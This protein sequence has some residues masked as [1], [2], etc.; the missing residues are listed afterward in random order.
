MEDAALVQ[1]LQR[2]AVERRTVLR[3]NW[4]WQGRNNADHAKFRDYFDYD[5]PFR[6]VCRPTDAGGVQQGAE[7]LMPLVL[8]EPPLPGGAVLHPKGRWCPWP[9]ERPGNTAR[10]ADDLIRKCRLGSA[11]QPQPVT[12][13]DLFT[14]PR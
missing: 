4:S 6:A 11:R 7:I 1:G 10:P 9:K 2:L 14:R 3:P 5:E 13:R 8:P 12:E